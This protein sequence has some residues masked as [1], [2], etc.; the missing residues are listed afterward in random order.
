[1]SAP[2][3]TRCRRRAQRDTVALNTSQDDDVERWKRI[4]ELYGAALSCAPDTRDA[5]LDDC[6]TDADVR[7]EVDSLLRAN[8]QAGRFL[9]SMQLAAHIRD[10]SADAGAS[11]DGRTL[12]PYA[13][14]SAIG[15]GATGKI[16]RAR[17]SRLGRLVALKILHPRFTHDAASLSR[18]IREARAASALNHPNIITVHD[19]GHVD[20][21]HFIATDLIEG[22]SLRER[23][24][25]GPR[26]LDEA[27]DVAMQCASALDAGHRADILHRD[28]KPENIMLRPDGLVKVVDFGLARMGGGG[29]GAESGVRTIPG[30]IMGTP[31]YM[32]PEQSRGQ[33][34]DARTDVFS[35]G[36]VLYEMV[37]GRP[38]FAGESTAEV[39]ASLLST[40]ADCA[41]PAFERL[42]GEL[43]SI[44]KKALEKD[45]E[46]RYQTI[47]A[48]GRDLRDLHRRLTTAHHQE[49]A[50]RAFRR[51]HGP[52]MLSVMAC[53]AAALVAAG[54]FALRPIS[55]LPLLLPVP[56]TSD[57]GSELEP[58]LSPD[59][60]RV[61]YTREVRES[62]P[63]VVVQ[64]I[65]TAR[66][67]P[68]VVGRQAFSAVW[69]P[70][71]DRLALLQ[72][73]GENS[74]R[75]DVVVV[76]VPSGTPRKIAEVDT[77][78][79]FQPFVP[80]AYLD[81]SPDGR[82]LVASDGWGATSQSHLVLISVETGDKVALTS[83]GAGTVGDF[84]P[85]F[86]YDGKRVAFARLRRLA[87]ADLFVLD[88]TSEMRPAGLS[89]KIASQDLWNAFPVWTPDNRHL[90]FAGGVFGSAR[91]K[92]VRVSGT[93][94][95]DLQV[96][97]AGIS[98]LD[99]R[100][101]KR[102]G[103]SRVVYTRFTGDSDIFR[104]G[105]DRPASRD[106]PPGGTPLIDSS[107]LD[108]LPQYAADGSAIAFV[109]TRT[110]SPQV[111]LARADGSESRQLTRLE[112]ADVHIQSVA[113]SPDNARLA[114][115][116]TRLD[117][118]GI[119]EV[120]ARDG[121]MRMLVDGDADMPVYSSDG[122]WLYFRVPDRRTP[123]TVRVPAKGGPP[124]VMTDLPPGVLRFTPDGKSVV[125]VSGRDV[126][127]RPVSGGR[128]LL[129]FSSIHSERSV[130]VAA[131]AVY[132]VTRAG[133]GHWGLAAWRFA[134][135]KIVPM[136][137]YGRDVGDGIAISPDERYAL[138][139]QREHQVLD[140]MLL[141]DVDVLRR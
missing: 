90:I 32:S 95:A 79:P 96:I 35:L 48:L 108:E 67:A 52:G 77:P 26:G 68:Q 55:S 134:D 109:S 98:T 14:L 137:A 101:A 125:Y 62:G 56:L 1:M 83:P 15:S 69:S 112:S 88:L 126:F 103:A 42:P 12:G 138:L 87:A 84:S 119:F 70:Q 136:A 94:R 47:D 124:E 54:W 33:P 10:I 102:S 118:A 11:L 31:R 133:S 49:R 141:D 38:R 45:R 60:M 100:P 122:R 37:V 116:L 63:E 89:T 46:R 139:T 3:A 16:Y 81:F 111:W 78:G 36:A 28:I 129:L 115:Q 121:T 27:L 51:A 132:A 59:G 18:F 6:C 135:R 130:A 44:L 4:E 82:F 92:L 66:S 53:G 71:G 86:S 43:K 50:G 93:Y 20:G 30:L 128:P 57:P 22:V 120:A 91:M 110:G 85:R 21:I 73:E 99:L 23:L 25:A 117:S 7:V 34:L 113:W 114:V 97:E 61:A 9:T 106:S 131:S 40:E 2:H 74:T 8:D 80:S 19:I 75:R 24:A 105:I 127:M 5:F 140:L 104:V 72:S 41:E 123:K 58:R 107:L 29:D 65:G 39:F 76:G 17:D 64:Q 13:I